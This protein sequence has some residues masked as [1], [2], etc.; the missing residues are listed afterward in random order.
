MKTNIH[1][2]SYLGQLFLEREMSQ[3]NVVENIKTHILCSIF[4]FFRK[5][6]CLWDN[7]QKL[8]TAWQAT[9]DSTAHVHCM[10]DI[11]RYKFT[12][13]VRNKYWFSTATIVARKRLNFT[14]YVHCLS[15][16][17]L[18][19]FISFTNCV[20]LW[21]QNPVFFRM[22]NVQHVYDGRKNS[23]CD[24]GLI[25][26][27]SQRGFFDCSPHSATSGNPFAYVSSSRKHFVSLA[28][29]FIFFTLLVLFYMWTNTQKI[30]SDK[31]MTFCISE[32]PVG[33][34]CVRGNLYFRNNGKHLK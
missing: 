5:S 27:D 25:V 3:T 19:I 8:R 16:T 9:D 26:S 20:T 29:V 32:C 34:I 14:L 2:W 21:I 11:S 30:Y 7:V 4:F 6:C 1:F 18:K 23:C 22:Y 33:G 10:L 12:H 31:N 17:A 24:K 15:C 13:V 28:R